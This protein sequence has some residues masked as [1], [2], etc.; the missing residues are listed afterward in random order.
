ME[1]WTAWIDGGS[2]GNPGEAGYGA[3]LQS[4]DGEVVEEL[5]G[6]L[7]EATN[8][9]AEYS[10][11]I[12]L[13][14]HAVARGIDHLTILSDSQLLVRQL[15]GTYRVKNPALQDLHRRALALLARID[16]H[17]LRHIPRAENKDADRLAN[18]AMNLR[19]SAGP[20]PPENDA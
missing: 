19:A 9:V 16:R 7:G 2:R 4:A 13:L 11:L 10:A 14:E 5:F 15:Q 8:N 3:R 6:Y 1:G 20:H 12:A 17:T 18:R